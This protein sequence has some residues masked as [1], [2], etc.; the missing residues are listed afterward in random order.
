MNRLRPKELCP[1]HKS[2]FCCGR[3]S[4]KKAMKAISQRGPVRRIEDPTH[5]RGFREICT[6]AE[7][8]RRKHRL[9]AT[10]E[11]TCVHCQGDL[12]QC[13]YDEIHL[14]HR[15]P[16]GQNGARHD[17]HISNLSLG[18]SACNFKNGSRRVA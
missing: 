7:L 2:Y 5:P 9:M 14:C 10:G 17:D 12:R 13:E 1:L 11:L 18:H 4:R 16:K 3:E 8:R 15:E 6:P